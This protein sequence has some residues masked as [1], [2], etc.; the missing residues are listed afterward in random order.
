MRPSVFF[1]TVLAT[2]LSGTGCGAQSN[3]LTAAAEATAA[4]D[5]KGDPPAATGAKEKAPKGAADQLDKDINLVRSGVG[6]ARILA[7]RRLNAYKAPVP[8]KQAEVAAALMESIEKTGDGYDEMRAL[9]IWAT[10]TELDLIPKYLGRGA[11]TKA[12]IYVLGKQKV[13]TAAKPLAAYLE[14]GSGDDKAL[15]QALIEIGSPS[16][17][18]VLPFLGHKDRGVVKRALQVLAQVGGEKSQGPVQK[19]TEVKEKDLVMAAKTTA[20]QIER[21]MKDEKKK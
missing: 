14:G 2:V 21:R 8:E 5:K 17:E 4:D 16:E 9:A 19:L 3:S 1:L 7:V 6:A 15:V 12:A 18:H 13:A 11:M 20:M 10:P